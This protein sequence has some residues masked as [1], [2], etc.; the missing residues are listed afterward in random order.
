M[1]GGSPKLPRGGAHTAEKSQLYKAQKPAKRRKASAGVRQI[2]LT[3]QKSDAHSS[4]LQ[5]RSTLMCR[6]GG[7]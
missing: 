2:R 5:K 7:R 3:L 6:N 1:A 4:H